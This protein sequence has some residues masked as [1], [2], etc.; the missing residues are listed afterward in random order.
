MKKNRL[1]FTLV[2]IMIVVAII[3]L[4]AAIAIPSFMK[5]RSTSQ[6]NSCIE[7][8]R[9]IEIETWSEQIAQLEQE[10]SG[11]K[12][13]AEEIAVTLTGAQEN[14][15]TIRVE[16]ATIEQEISGVEADGRMEARPDFVAGQARRVLAERQKNSGI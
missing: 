14:V 13:R 3:G 9:Q 2:E 7:N 12:A 8:L 10:S 11:Q 16:L 1:G 6:K 4:L 15:E 5:A